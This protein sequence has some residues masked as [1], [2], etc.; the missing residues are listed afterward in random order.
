MVRIAE[1][2]DILV[3]A[4]WDGLGG[5]RLM[6][7]L[8]AA[9]ARG[10]EVFSFEYDR[11]WLTDVEAQALDPRLLLFAGPQYA[12]EG[13][14]NFGLFLDSSPDRWGRLL[15]DRR[16]SLEARSAGRPRRHLHESDYLLGVYDD[17]RMGALRFKLDPAGPFLDDNR[18]MASPPWASLRDLEHA[19]LEIEAKDGP[20]DADYTRWLNLLLAPGASLGGARPKAGVVDP[21]GHL[22]IAKFPRAADTTDVGAWEYVA[23]TLASAAGVVVAAA[24]CRR[25]TVVWHTF[26]TRRFDRTD[27]G[28]RLQFAS[29]LT[30]LNRRDGDDASVGASYLELAEVLL[31]DGASPARDLEQLWTRIVFNICVSNCDDH[32]RN[33]G[34]LLRRTGWALAPAYDM[35]PDAYGN[36]L[37]LNISDS[38][39]AQDLALAGEVAGYFRITDARATE[40]TDRV[41]ATVRRWR[42]AARDAGIPAD[43]Q[44]KMAPAFQAAERQ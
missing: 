25:L 35:N 22:W 24:A 13:G 7:V 5:A 17:Y 30:A 31:R 20:T 27:S 16:E 1:Q 4:D 15:M 44:D 8:H 19:S 41:T 10:R 12:P 28:S 3:Y 42:S 18:G 43:E 2:C 39:N 29:A 6:G 14:A 40:I 9:G 36:G 32:L 33:H 11:A 34:F 37:S 26:L 38:D 23:H 21:D